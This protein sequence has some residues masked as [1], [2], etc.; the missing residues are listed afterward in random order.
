MFPRNVIRDFRIC[1][2][3]QPGSSRRNLLRVFCMNYPNHKF[4]VYTN[5]IEDP[6]LLSVLEMS[7]FMNPDDARTFQ[8]QNIVTFDPEIRLPDPSNIST[9][10]SNSNTYAQMEDDEEFIIS[11][12]RTGY[13]FETDVGIEESIRW[14]EDNFC[15]IRA[16]TTELGRVIDNWRGNISTANLANLSNIESQA[17]SIINVQNIN[18]LLHD[19]RHTLL[20]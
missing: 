4:Y 10:K 11:S 20:H 12:A 7:S 14:M 17:V 1:V 15:Q 16:K 2:R 6:Q 13:R 19:L 18:T 5:I 9:L 3:A 8:N